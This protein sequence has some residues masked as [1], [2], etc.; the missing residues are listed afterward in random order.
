MRLTLFAL[1]L[2]SLFVT[3]ADSGNFIEG[4]HACSTTPVVLSTASIP[5]KWLNVQSWADNTG[6]VFVGQSGVTAVANCHGAGGCIT[7]GG[8]F[9]LP[10][11]GSAQYNL[12]QVYI[13]CTVAGDSVSYVGLQ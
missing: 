7:P 9:F 5:L 13:V 10:T 12:K 3:Q 1:L 8:A 2:A 4:T 11:D 6:Q